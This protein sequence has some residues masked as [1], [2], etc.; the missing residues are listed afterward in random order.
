MSD[1]AVQVG[2]VAKPSQRKAQHQ[3]QDGK[4]TAKSLTS[5]QELI[6]LAKKV[7]K[8][9]RVITRGPTYRVSISPPDVCT[10]RQ[11]EPKVKIRRLIF[12][13]CSGGN[14]FIA[15]NFLHARWS[16]AF[17]D[18]NTRSLC[19]LSSRGSMRPLSCRKVTSTFV[20]SRS[21]SV[22]GSVDSGLTTG[23]SVVVEFDVACVAN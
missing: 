10:P 3:E 23:F 20:Y 9:L 19:S 12:S 16:N 14:F 5:S 21:S 4:R 18:A 11:N 2:C 13:D 22:G 17:N 1:Q 8:S 7:K 15:Q 6:S